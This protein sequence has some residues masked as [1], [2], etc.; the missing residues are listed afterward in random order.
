MISKL[1]RHER[2]SLNIQPHKLETRKLCQFR[3]R[4]SIFRHHGRWWWIGFLA[5]PIQETN[6]ADKVARAIACKSAA[7]IPGCDT[8]VVVATCCY[9][10]KYEI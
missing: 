5:E 1:A 2:I 8:I 4:S 6:P 7:D 10:W 3:S 9:G